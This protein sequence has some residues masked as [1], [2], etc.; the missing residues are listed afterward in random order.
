MFDLL[1]D[2]FLL[3]CDD[4]PASCDGDGGNHIPVGG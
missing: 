3:L 2:L 4:G 1:I